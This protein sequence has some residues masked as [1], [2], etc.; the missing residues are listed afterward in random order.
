MTRLVVRI[1]PA[2]VI[3]DLDPDLVAERLEGVSEWDTTLRDWRHTDATYLTVEAERQVLDPQA[4]DELA[5]AL[6]DLPAMAPMLWR[7]SSPEIPLAEADMAAVREAAA[8][9]A[10]R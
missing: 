6:S 9:A 2:Q 4:V 5:A 7:R 8:D 3:E 1:R 10:E